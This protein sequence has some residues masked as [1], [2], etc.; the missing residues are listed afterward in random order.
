MKARCCC[1]HCCHLHPLY[2]HCCPVHHQAWGA[3]S[4]RCGQ[5]PLHG[6][7]L[8]NL[9]S[10]PYN[11]QAYKKSRG[12]KRDSVGSI[13]AGSH[14]TTMACSHRHRALHFRAENPRVRSQQEKPS[15]NE[16]QETNGTRGHLAIR[17]QGQGRRDTTG[18][19]GSLTAAVLPNAGRVLMP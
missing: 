14:A 3:W 2:F 12:E 17:G 18:C 6:G 13:C 10:H 5:M 15:L 11:R 8:Q 9:S 19:R 7:L 1:R 4:R 16:G